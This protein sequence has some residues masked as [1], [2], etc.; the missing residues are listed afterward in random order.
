MGIQRMP[1]LILLFGLFLVPFILSGCTIEG[2]D[3]EDEIAAT[4]DH[5]GQPE[6][7]SSTG[8]NN[9]F[10][11]TLCY[12]ALGFKKTFTWGDGDDIN[13]CCNEM[14]NT[15][16]GRSDCQDDDE[17]DPPVAVDQ[18]VYPQ[19]DEPKEIELSAND[20]DGDPLT[21]HI[22]ARP[23]K[24]QLDPPRTSKDGVFTYTPNRNAMDKD[25]DEFTFV[26]ND[27]QD[28]STNATVMIILGNQVPKA[29]D[30]EKAL[31][32]KLGNEVTIHL[33]GS[34]RN[35]DT[36]TYELVDTSGVTKGTLKAS[37]LN[38]VTGTVPYVQG[39]GAYE[40]KFTYKV[41]DSKDAESNTGTVT[42]IVREPKA[43]A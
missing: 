38:R 10:T 40:E 41:T 34:D 13:F 23:G 22:T 5:F 33:V 42:I 28:D 2:C 7:I 39:A 43:A 31:T 12:I 27:G 25:T 20:P 37:E 26:V 11:M 16:T 14:T 6:E 18:E 21:Y 17:N 32:V 24:G 36:L 15:I 3:C 8:D 4:Y 19:L 29:K 30:V 9:E 35:E 1:R